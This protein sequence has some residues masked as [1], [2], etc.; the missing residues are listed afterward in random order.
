MTPQTA[1][2]V[3]RRPW[4]RRAEAVSWRSSR[5]GCPRCPVRRSTAG[6]KP[7]SRTKSPSARRAYAIPPR[8]EVRDKLE[9]PTA[10]RI[11]GGMVQLRHPGSAPV[12][13]LDPDHAVPRLDRDRDRLAG[14][15]PLCRMLL[16]NNRSR[17]R[18]QHPCS[19][20]WDPA[21]LPRRRGRPAPAQ[22]APQAS[23]SPPPA[24]L[25][26]H[27]PSR[28]APPREITGRRAD[29]PGCTLDSA[30]HVKPGYAPERAPEPRQA[31]THTAPW[32]RFPSAMRPWTPQHGGI[33]RIKVTHHGTE[34]KRPA[35]T[36]IR[37]YWGVFAGGGR[38][39]VRTNVG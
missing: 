36:R 17:A 22:P 21:R 23:R 15:K 2:L 6:W 39:W 32:H 27:P 25:S 13:D 33:Q 14:T 7:A 3:G 5:S 9:P 16:P 30:A 37:S 34:Q 1:R 11:T 29:T 31:A 35:S 24:Q 38:C 20:N 19:G 4:R 28:P 10:F 8:R 18:Q 26:P 12:G